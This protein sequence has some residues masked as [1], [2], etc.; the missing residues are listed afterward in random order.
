M[1]RGNRLITAFLGKVHTFST[2][3]TGQIAP[4]AHWEIS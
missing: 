4:V 3:T 1:L 2:A